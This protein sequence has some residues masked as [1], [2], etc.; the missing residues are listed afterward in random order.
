MLES[1]KNDEK[2][3]IN[4]VKMLRNGKSVYIASVTEEILKYEV[5]Y[6]GVLI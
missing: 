3:V 2:Q 5:V 1:K 4:I 6:F